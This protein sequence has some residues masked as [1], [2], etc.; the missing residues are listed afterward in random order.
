MEY[1]SLHG[2][3]RNT[4]S[5]TDVQAEH[6]LRADKSTWPVE[7][8]IQNHT[9]LR[10]TKILGGETEVLV[11]LD[12]PLAGGE[13]RQGSDP[14]SGAIVWVRG[15]TFKVESETPKFKV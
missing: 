2:Y 1:I 4:P 7:K 9:K 5:D 13:L 3:M 10:R 6:Q 12:L 11:G 14:H 8:T 15:E